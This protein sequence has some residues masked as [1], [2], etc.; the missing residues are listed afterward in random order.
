ME[1]NRK[2]RDKPINTWSINLCQEPRMYNRERTISLINGV[3]NTGQL[4]KNDT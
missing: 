2:P 1:R 3:R 4:Q